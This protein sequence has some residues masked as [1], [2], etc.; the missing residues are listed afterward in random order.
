MIFVILLSLFIVLI[1]KDRNKV[2][3]SKV[4]P[5]AL[6]TPT[7]SPTLKPTLPG[8]TRYESKELKLS[9]QLP[10]NFEVTNDRTHDWGTEFGTKYAIT[11]SLS[12][13]DL[14]TLQTY[15][16][17]LATIENDKPFGWEGNPFWY[18]PSLDKS[19]SN[20]EFE[21]KLKKYYQNPIHIKDTYITNLNNFAKIVYLKGCYGQCILIRTY[22]IPFEKQIDNKIYHTLTFS[23][24][25]ADL[26]Y[27]DQ[28]VENNL[29]SL[30]DQIKQDRF[31]DNKINL[32]IDTQD[33]IV[34]SLK[35]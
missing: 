10:L 8:N 30:M 7:N 9:F 11:K 32:I 35:F 14:G 22:Y 27:D 16:F 15:G 21:V 4:T 33:K 29:T 1:P 2:E 17:G 26:G 12:I 18:V 19:N 13:H 20:E 31:S 24:T 5:E 28:M 25:I 3:I 6:I 23:T 34:K